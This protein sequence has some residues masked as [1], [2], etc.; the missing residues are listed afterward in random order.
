MAAIDLMPSIHLEY[1]VPTVSFIFYDRI[2]D[3]W[4]LHIYN[5]DTTFHIDLPIV[6]YMVSHGNPKI[7]YTALRVIAT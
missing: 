5:L 2:P 1:T 6:L 3:I 4:N 7:V